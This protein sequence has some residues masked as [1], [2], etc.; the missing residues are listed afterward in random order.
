MVRFKIRLKTDMTYVFLVPEKFDYWS[1]MSFPVI[2]WFISGEISAEK[3][4]EHLY[5]TKRL[6][7]EFQ[8]ESLELF[9]ATVL[10]SAV[11]SIL[12]DFDSLL[13]ARTVTVNS[14][15]LELCL[16]QTISSSRFFTVVHP[17][18]TSGITICSTLKASS[19]LGQKMT[20][21]F[22]T[23]SST[24]SAERPGPQTSQITGVN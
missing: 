15:F 3:N 16:N 22:W 6:V 18:I 8:G 23:N 4:S 21:T 24:F 11:I 17:R 20:L 14:S 13:P 12:E 9:W 5:R 2:L 10:I 7:L 19:G 1:K